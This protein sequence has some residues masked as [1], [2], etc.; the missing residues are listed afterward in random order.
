MDQITAEIEQ[1]TDIN[2]TSTGI[3]SQIQKSVIDFNQSPQ[4]QDD[5]IT[6]LT[7]FEQN[8]KLSPEFQQIIN[9][10]DDEACD[11]SFN[12]T[13]TASEIENDLDMDI[14]DFADTEKIFDDEDALSE[15]FKLT[16]GIPMFDELLEKELGTTDLGQEQQIPQ[17]TQYQVLKTIQHQIPHTTQYQVPKTTKHQIPNRTQYQNQYSGSFICTL[18]QKDFTAM[19]SLTRHYKTQKHQR[20]EA[21][22]NGHP[23]VQESVYN[24]VQT[25]NYSSIQQQFYQPKAS[26]VGQ[27][28]DIFLNKTRD[29]RNIVADQN[30]MNSGRKIQ[31]LEEFVNTGVGGSFEQVFRHAEPS[32]VQQ[33]T[34][35]APMLSSPSVTKTSIENSVKILSKLNTETSSEQEVKADSPTRKQNNMKQLTLMD[36]AFR[37]PATKSAEPKFNIEAEDILDSFT[38]ELGSDYIEII[39]DDIISIDQE[40]EQPLYEIVISADAGFTVN[41]LEVPKSS[42]Q[43]QS[44]LAKV[45]GQKR[46]RRIKKDISSS[47]NGHQCNVCQRPFATQSNLRR[48]EHLHGLKKLHQCKNCGKEFM[49]NEYL[50]KHMVTHGTTGSVKVQ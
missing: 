10:N 11:S 40:D 22:M 31:I 44:G 1:L 25:Q 39:P 38:P 21:R 23:Q 32:L 19:T 36:M 24:T 12:S 9:S 49:Q 5:F 37:K 28:R 17:M 42:T 8:L 33:L 13:L 16:E 15:L 48:H 46:Q 30:R 35:A 20:M 43:H 45:M 50:K 14:E 41:K 26:N 6:N 4:N 47:Y 3:F 7:E 27:R 29:S 18:C 2:T 34:E